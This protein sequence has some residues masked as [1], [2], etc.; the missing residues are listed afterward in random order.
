MFNN[1]KV[2]LVQLVDVT[3][4]VVSK[5]IKIIFFL[6]N[7]GHQAEKL[8]NFANVELTCITIR[9][10]DLDCHRRRLLELI[11]VLLIRV[12]VNLYIGSAGASCGRWSR[13]GSES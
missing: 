8:S 6:K 11:K 2:V 4:H 5:S 1:T 3:N 7:S 9:G 13:N 10:V 12:V